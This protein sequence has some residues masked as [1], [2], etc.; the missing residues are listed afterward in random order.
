M[1]QD[2]LIGVICTFALMAS[3]FFGYHMAKID[4]AQECG[5]TGTFTRAGDVYDCKKRTKQ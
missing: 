5:L 1:T 3:V 4:V 2:H